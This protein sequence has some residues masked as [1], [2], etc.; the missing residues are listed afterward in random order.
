[1][2]DISILFLILLLGLGVNYFYPKESKEDKILNSY[3]VNKDQNDLSEAFNSFDNHLQK[4]FKS[5][6]KVNRY[7]YFFVGIISENPRFWEIMKQQNL[8]QDTIDFIND[9]AQRREEFKEGIFSDEYTVSK[10]SL[11]YYWA[12]FG[13]T[14]DERVLEKM[15]KDIINIIASNAGACARA[16][17]YN[18]SVLSAVAKSLNARA[19]KDEKVKTFVEG[20]KQD[21]RLSENFRKL[22]K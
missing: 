16:R 11:D 17:E 14:G 15:R 21:Y 5:Y 1:M 4:R 3:Y 8:S 9:F 20:L 6:D 18:A 10:E 13:A 7:V 12:Y 19:K 22:L 2:K